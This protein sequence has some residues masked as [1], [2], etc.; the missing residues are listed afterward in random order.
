MTATVHVP[1]GELVLDVV[2][3]GPRDADVVVLLH[4]FPQS[5][6]E[7]RSVWPALTGAGYRVVAPDQRGYSPGARPDGVE[8]Y[9]MAHLVGDVVGL[10]DALEVERAHVVG[11]DW[12]AAVAWQVAG[13]HPA[14]VRSLT[15]V[16]VP[17]PAAFGAA[18]RSDPD[19][20]ER[21]QYMLAFN[22]PDAEERL[23]ADGG[24]WLRSGFGDLPD[25]DVY[26]R[27]MQE[28]GALTAALAWYRAQAA[29]MR[30]PLPA[31]T[32]P[33][34]YVWSDA[35]AALGP[36]PAHA[37]ASHVDGPYR[38]EVL[39]GVSH[40]VPEQA[41]EQLSGLLLEHLSAQTPG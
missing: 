6:W 19:Q 32:V 27:R 36:V 39:H 22:E 35:D 4:G 16:S 9:A 18:L 30:D 20:R 13:R 7:W 40:W 24:A 15:A 33:T 25:G 14:R 41:P 21:S 5:S 11:H 3:L 28:P 38:F 23:L 17:H 26:L 10:L 1:V 2:D 8:P 34:L 29:G 31:V 12:G 37:T